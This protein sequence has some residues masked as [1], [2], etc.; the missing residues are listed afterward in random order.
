MVGRAQRGQFVFMLFSI[1]A[2]ANN[3]HRCCGKLPSHHNRRLR[4]LETQRKGI[5]YIESH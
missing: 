5:K 2:A 4:L 3:H 1:G